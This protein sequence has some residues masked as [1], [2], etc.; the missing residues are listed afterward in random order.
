MK[1]KY[2]VLYFGQAIGD[3][4]YPVSGYH[5][6]I[7]EEGSKELAFYEKCIGGYAFGGDFVETH[8]ITEVEND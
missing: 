4:G 1:K 5:N 8:S 3:D 7:V 6:E 2:S